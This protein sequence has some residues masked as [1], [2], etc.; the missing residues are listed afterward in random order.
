M[1]NL[2]EIRVRISSVK[3]TKQITSAMKLVA[4]AKLKRATDRATSAKPYQQ[5]LA[6]VLSR[7]AARVG[8]VR[9]PLLDQRE[10]VQ[11]VLVVALTSDRGLCGGFNTNL[12]RQLR[13]WHGEQPAKVHLRVYG[14]K[15]VSF[16]D[17]HEIPYDDSTVDYDKTPVMDLVR[18]LT[19]EMVRKFVSGEVDRVVLAHNVFVNTLVQRP[20]FTQVL[21]LQIELD[22][23]GD[24]DSLVDYQYEP[25]APRLLRTL[26]PLYLRTVLLQTFLE[27]NAGEFA[28]RMTAMESATNNASDLISSLNLQYNRARQAAIT[29]EIIEIVSGAEAL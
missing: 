23:D 16:L 19:D 14:R 13:T 9:D 10:E 7:V 2:K 8:D 15:G 11:D 29:N 17:F 26:L 20:T 21:P 18:D 25:D 3:K 24:G 6:A 5:Q 12:L 1:A 28:A 22:G 4:T 27:T